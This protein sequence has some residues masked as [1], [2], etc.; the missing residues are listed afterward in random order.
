MIYKCHV[1]YAKD[2]E[3]I[4][5]EPHGHRQEWHVLSGLLCFCFPCWKMNLKMVI[6]FWTTLQKTSWHE[7]LVCGWSKMDHFVYTFV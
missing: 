7:L 3:N 5:R 2:K 4:R 1:M 6:V